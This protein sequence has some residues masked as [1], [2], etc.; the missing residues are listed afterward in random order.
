[1]TLLAHRVVVV[2]CACGSACFASSDDQPAPADDAIVGALVPLPVSC[3]E[4]GEPVPDPFTQQDEPRC[5]APIR[6]A[7]PE[8]I[9][10][11]DLSGWGP[12]DPGTCGGVDI[13]E[14]IIP[15]NMIELPADQEFPLRIRLPAV[16]VTDPGCEECGEIVPAATVFGLLF[17]IRNVTGAVAVRV[18]KPW[19]WVT[20]NEGS[21]TYCDTG[22]PSFLEHGR[23]MACLHFGG[24]ATFGLVATQTTSEPMDVILDLVDA[25]PVGCCPYTCVEWEHT[26]P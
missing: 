5:A 3:V 26:E 6:W 7:L 10:T 19:Y 25:S 24:T 1:M 2:V 13:H 11:L 20:G 8:P 15:S 22:Y 16:P 23:P 9:A 21:P 18:P 12:A 4:T 14:A 17:D